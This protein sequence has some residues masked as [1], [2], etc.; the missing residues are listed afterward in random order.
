MDPAVPVVGVFVSTM[1]NMHVPNTQTTTD[2]DS[3]LLLLSTAPRSSDINY[4]LPICR[5]GYAASAMPV[6]V[7]PFKDVI[8][9]MESLSLLRKTKKE[10]ALANDIVTR[11]RIAKKQARAS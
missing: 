5:S 4:Y 9:A 10:A 3:V 6:Y 2:T 1:M 11:P 7:V 8:P